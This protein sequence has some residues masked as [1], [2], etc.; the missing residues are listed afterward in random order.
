VGVAVATGRLTPNAPRIRRYISAWRRDSGRWTIAALLFLGM[1]SVPATT[2]P[3]GLPLAL[4]PAQ[5]AGAAAPL[6]AADLAFAKLA[7]GSGAAIAFQRWAAREAMIFGGG[8]L[9]IR[10]PEAIGRAVAGPARWRWHPVAAGAA[11]SGDLGWTAGEA[12]ITP[13]EAK[14]DY[15]K[16]LTVWIRRPGQR[17]RFLIDGG[18]AR[19]RSGSG[20]TPFPSG[21]D[22]G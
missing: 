19:P 22:S 3:R 6:I 1:D 9:L 2:L 21:Q 15:S 8:G 7:G 12:V 20:P 13:R 4:N 5:P 14:P 11:Q 18:N 17:I 16:Y 10:G